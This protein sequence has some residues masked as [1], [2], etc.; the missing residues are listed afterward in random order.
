MVAELQLSGQPNTPIGLGDGRHMAYP[1]GSRGIATNNMRFDSRDKAVSF[2]E[3]T[4]RGG[5]NSFQSSEGYTEQ[6]SK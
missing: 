4:R 6:P 1:R 5:L 3:I 2:A